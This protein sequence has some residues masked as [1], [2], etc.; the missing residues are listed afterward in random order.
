MA[1]KYGLEIE[2]RTQTTISLK[3]PSGKIVDF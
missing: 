2:E 1:E 3:T